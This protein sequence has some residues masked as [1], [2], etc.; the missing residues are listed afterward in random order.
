MMFDKITLTAYIADDSQMATV[1]LGRYWKSC[2]IEL[3]DDLELDDVEEMDLVKI[4]AA[5]KLAKRMRKAAL[6]L[7]PAS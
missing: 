2:T 7:E 1:V 5:C 4:L 3:P 6:L